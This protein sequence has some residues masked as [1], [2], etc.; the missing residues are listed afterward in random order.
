VRREL[1]HLIR[2]GISFLG[3]IK[4]APK[5]RPDLI[6]I[7]FRL[8]YFLGS[9]VERT[10]YSARMLSP[11]FFEDAPDLHKFCGNVDGTCRGSAI[12]LEKPTF[13]LASTLFP[14]PVTMTL[15]AASPPMFAARSPAMTTSLEF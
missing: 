4:G 7:R 12:F 11:Q 13:I 3:I 14:T 1:F 8:A 9:I 2:K 6:L 10:A 5:S 15:P